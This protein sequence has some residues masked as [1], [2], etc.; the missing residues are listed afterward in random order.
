MFFRQKGKPK[1]KSKYKILDATDQESLELKPTSRAGSS[2]GS[3]GWGVC[4]CTPC[5]EPLSLTAVGA[6]KA[7]CVLPDEAEGGLGPVLAEAACWTSSDAKALSSP[8]TLQTG[9][10]S[11]S[12]LPAYSLEFRSSSC[13]V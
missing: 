5:E 4:L 13:P 3:W 1:R 6:G 2:P 10:A 7:F 9:E 12:P 8:F 11:C